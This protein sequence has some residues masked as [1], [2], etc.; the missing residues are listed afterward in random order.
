[1]QE[2]PLTVEDQPSAADL[3]FLEDQI[4]AYNMARV[5]AYD[6]RDLAIFVRDKAGRI[7]AGISGYTWAGFCEIQFLWVDESLRQRSYGTQLLRS[8]EEEARARGCSLIV[9]GSYSFQAPDFYRRHGYEVVG[10]VEDCPVGY[11][12]YYFRKPLR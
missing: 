2:A 1:M 7:V 12:H 8:A 4:N 3:N 11:V 5:G 9:L 10:L 6:G